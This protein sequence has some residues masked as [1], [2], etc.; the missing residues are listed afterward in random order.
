MG[1]S[2]LVRALHNKGS[3]GWEV[4]SLAEAAVKRG[5]DVIILSVGDPDFAT[6][7][8]IVDSAVAALRSGDTHY[9]SMGGRQELRAAIAELAAR[10]TGVSYGIDLSLIHI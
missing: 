1:F 5:E 10:R 9:T 8:P 7:E 4:H 3:R 2:P 6:P